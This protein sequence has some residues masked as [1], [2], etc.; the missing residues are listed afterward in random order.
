[1]PSNYLVVRYDAP[2]AEKEVG[3]G[4][5]MQVILVFDQC[6]SRSN[7]VIVVAKGCTYRREAM[8]DVTPSGTRKS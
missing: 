7:P 3:V 4:G 5:V 2:P 6:L 1:M 8:S